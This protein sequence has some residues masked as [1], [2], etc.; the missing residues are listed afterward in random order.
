[1]FS[2]LLVP[3]LLLTSLTCRVVPPNKPTYNDQCE[4]SDATY[5]HMM[6]SDKYVRWVTYLDGTAKD[7]LEYCRNGILNKGWGI[8]HK[9]WGISKHWNNFSSAWPSEVPLVLLA[10]DFY[11]DPIEK[12]AETMCHEYT[13]VLQWEGETTKVMLPQYL[14][15]EGTLAYEIPANR[16]S[17]IIWAKFRKPSVAQRLSFAKRKV[18]TLFSAYALRGVPECIKPSLELMIVNSGGFELR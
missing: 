14:V 10:S 12:Q 18:E 6:V 9:L 3:L 4:P 7:T 2:R 16:V 11:D 5:F 8:E 13:H 1:M 15:S 17:Y